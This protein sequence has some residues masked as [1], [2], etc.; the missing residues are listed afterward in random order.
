MPAK[1]GIQ[2]SRAMAC[3]GYMDPRFR[4]GDRT[5]CV[6]QKSMALQ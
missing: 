5:V 2:A 1:A 6:D 3:G 4:G